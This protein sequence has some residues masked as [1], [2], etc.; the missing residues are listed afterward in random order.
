MIRRSILAGLAVAGFALP[1]AAQSDNPDFRVNNR[2]AMPI[3]EIYVS[4]SADPNW[5]RDLLGENVLPVGNAFLVQLPAGQCV[6]DIRIVWSNGQA[7]ERRQVNTC[8]LT[9]IAFP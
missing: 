5:G 2:G 3:N 6:N 7:Q 9:D 4:S 8:N 1:A